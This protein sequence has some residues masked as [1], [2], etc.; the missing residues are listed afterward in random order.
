MKLGDI[1]FV[2]TIN[3]NYTLLYSNPLNKT[4][5]TIFHWI[6]NDSNTNIIDGPIFRIGHTL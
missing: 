4:F 6:T 3:V 1:E 5:D 2:E